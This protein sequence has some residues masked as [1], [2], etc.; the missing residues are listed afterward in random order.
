MTI[1]DA[2]EMIASA[3]FTPE[4]QTWLDLGC[5]S[6]TFTLALAA[7]LPKGSK[8]IGVDKSVQKLPEQS[9]NGN[10]IEFI[11]QNISEVLNFNEE[12]SGVLMANSL[13]Y[14]KNQSEFIQQLKN[15]MPNSF[16]LIMVEYDSD[17]PNQ[18][19]PFPVFV[20]RLHKLFKNDIFN[21]EKLALS[22]E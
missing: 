22:F 21:I 12:I 18:W 9:S 20:T 8:V 15:L 2:K 17:I 7:L 5:G 11:Q 14:I 4:S 13:H 10:S 6:G 1:S 19:V 16:N 3:K